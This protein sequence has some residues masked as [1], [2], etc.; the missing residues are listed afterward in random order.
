MRANITKGFTVV[1]FT[2]STGFLAMYRKEIRIFGKL[3]EIG[4]NIGIYLPKKAT[5]RASFAFCILTI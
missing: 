5:L 3:A 1:D 4:C 2:C